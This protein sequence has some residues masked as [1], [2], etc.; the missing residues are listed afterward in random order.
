M[1]EPIY[2]ETTEALYGRLPAAY[3]QED[4]NQGWVLKTWLSG[5]VDQAGDVEAFINRASY[6]TPDDGGSPTDS[7][8]L[9]DPEKA[10]A[11]WLPWIAQVLGKKINPRFTEQQTRDYLSTAGYT[12]GT[13]KAIA[14][15][16]AS[17][18]VGTRSVTVYDHTT[19]TS[20]IGAGG[21]W[22]VLI[23]TKASETLENLVPETIATTADPTLFVGNQVVMADEDPALGLYRDR[24]L[25]FTKTGANGAMTI[26][27]TAANG[28]RIPVTAGDTVVAFF[29][30]LS[31]VAYAGTIQINFYD[32]ANALL[33]SVTQPGS[34]IPANALTQLSFG[35]TVPA[36]AVSCQITYAAAMNVGEYIDLAQFGLR[37]GAVT[38][39]VPRT[40]D[41]IQSVINAGAKP[42][43]I[44]LWKRT[45]EAS[46]D[47]V[48]AAY[49]TWDARDAKTWTQIEETGL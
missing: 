42:A 31:P 40:V 5:V 30:A 36:S 9:A 35:F 27:T 4:E 8:A 37:R 45:A 13:K 44:K 41:P 6:D 48:E 12:S 46:W 23:V 3:R 33:S 11:A 34:N 26:G 20:A 24:A 1:P 22:D 2:S 14:E 29:S 15:A 7:S 47:A 18:L 25:R 39:W 19:D 28:Q 38:T 17:E 49:T 43:G 32:A 10:D 16:A 21:Q